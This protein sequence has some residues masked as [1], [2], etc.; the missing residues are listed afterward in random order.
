MCAGA[1]RIVF[2][3]Q[4]AGYSEQEQQLTNTKSA[5]KA[6]RQSVKRAARNR[7]IRSAVRTYVKKATAAVAERA[8]Q[9]TEIVREAVSAL[10]RAARKGIIHPNA[11]A[12]RKSRLMSRLHALSVTPAAAV[13]AVPASR[14]APKKP[15]AK[16][17]S[18]GGGNKV[19][20]T[21]STRRAAALK[22]A[23][24]RTAKP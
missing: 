15:A 22:A 11:A 21:A 16:K 9:A 24:T 1:G 8:D 23:T 2:R 20:V 4:T 10:D 17:T 5:Q 6:H 13:V 7:P 19:M 3:R 18:T 14:G 12:R